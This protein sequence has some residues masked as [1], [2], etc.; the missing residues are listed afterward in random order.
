M[1]AE[2]SLYP[3]K[4]VTRKGFKD[5]SQVKLLHILNMQFVEMQAFSRNLGL[6]SSNFQHRI[7]FTGLELI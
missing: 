1:S 6:L 4:L 5:F 2:A 3:T 7:M